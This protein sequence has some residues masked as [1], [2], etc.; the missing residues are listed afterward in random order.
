MDIINIY[1]IYIYH[2]HM[3]IFQRINLKRQKKE[4]LA[5]TIYDPKFISTLEF[6]LY[7]IG[8]HAPMNNRR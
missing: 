8:K 5:T 7:K 3:H 1:H 2:T 4:N 6:I